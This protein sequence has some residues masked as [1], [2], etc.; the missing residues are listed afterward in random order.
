[1]KNRKLQRAKRRDENADGCAFKGM[2]LY[3]ILF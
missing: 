2:N 3:F 1:M